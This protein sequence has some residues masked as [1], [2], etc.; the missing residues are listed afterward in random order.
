MQLDALRLLLYSI[1]PRI[2]ATRAAAL[3]LV[4]KE[5]RG[6]GVVE[7]WRLQFGSQ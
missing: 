6:S 3:L 2:V 4:E 1:S 5:V 7:G